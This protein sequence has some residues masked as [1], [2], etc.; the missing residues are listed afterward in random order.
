MTYFC[1]SDI[2]SYYNIFKDALSDS[3]F[4]IN[5]PDHK[6]VICGDLFDR[7]EGAVDLFNF[8]KNLPE[9]K[10]IYIRGNHE[11]LLEECLEEMERYIIPSEHHFH[12]GTVDTILQ[13]CNLSRVELWDMYYKWRDEIKKDPILEDD[14]PVPHNTHIFRESLSE[15]LNFIDKK[16]I[17]YYEKGDY[18]FVHGWIPTLNSA[19]TLYQARHLNHTFL[20]TWRSASP[21]QWS[22]ARWV[23]GMEAW[24][25]G[26]KEPGKTIVCGHWHCSYYWSQIKHERKEFPEKN[27]P[28]WQKSFEPALD[29]GLIALDG[30]TA[31]SGRVNIIKIEV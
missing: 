28:D 19:S 31:Y 24:N 9:D 16:C 11:D 27:R 21:T 26:V 14:V 2:H 15:V 7:G 23:N 18:I 20:P 29:E 6:L 5:N 4:D 3:G 10:L 13:F 25:K 8:V 30:C 12:N 17:D 22:V 1:C